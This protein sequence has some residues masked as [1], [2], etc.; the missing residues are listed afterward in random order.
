MGAVSSSASYRIEVTIADPDENL[1]AGMT[2]KLSIALE[3]SADA[4]TVPYDAVTTTPDGTSTITV[5]VDGEKKTITVETGLETDYYTEVISDELSEGMTVYLSTPMIS[6]TIDSD[7][8]M[9]FPGGLNSI[10]PGGGD[11]PSGGGNRGGGGDMPSGG[12]G[13]PSGGGPG[14]F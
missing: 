3:E 5:D 11:M 12:G 14:G 8:E 4:L 1:R 2:A 9:S 13:M 10:M 6:T 7:E